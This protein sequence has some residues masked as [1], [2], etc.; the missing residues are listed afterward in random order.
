MPNCQWFGTRADHIQLIEDIFSRDEVEVWEG[1]SDAN[2]RLRRYHATAEVL[3]ALEEPWPNGAPRSALNLLL[4]I[5]GAGPGIQ[6]Q[7]VDRTDGTWAEHAHGIG[8]LTFRLEFER[9]DGTLGYS[10]TNTFTERG[11]GA[12]AGM[13]EDATGQHWDI[14]RVNRVSATLNRRIRKQGVG[15]IGSVRVLRGALALWQAGGALRPWTP[16]SHPA[17]VTL[18]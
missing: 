3:A 10:T 5:K 14:A 9:P 16:D 18:F 11:L 6:V 12:I 7:H 13:Y 1:A 15:K 17:A 8:C 4:W 2:Q